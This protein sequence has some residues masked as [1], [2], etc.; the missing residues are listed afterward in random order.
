MIIL[1]Q[2]VVIFA[3][4]VVLFDSI[5]HINRMNIKTNHLIRASYILIAIGA[6]G[7]ITAILAGHAP[8]IAETLFVIGW[9]ALTFVDQR[10]A[11]R[12]PLVPTKTSS[13]FSKQR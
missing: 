13:F 1:I 8:G 12:C 2:M 9:G 4:A 11:F 3:A 6:F 5:G 10:D 7:E